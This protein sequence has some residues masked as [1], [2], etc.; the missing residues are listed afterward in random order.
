MFLRHPCVGVTTLRAT[1]FATPQLHSLIQRAVIPVSP[2]VRLAG[3]GNE[4]GLLDIALCTAASIESVAAVV[5]ATE[6]GLC[7]VSRNSLSYFTIP[8]FNQS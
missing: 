7:R 1:I 4:R 3:A 6:Y 8:E 2:S 5:V